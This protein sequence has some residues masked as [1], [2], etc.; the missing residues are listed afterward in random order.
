VTPGP[1]LVYYPEAAEAESYRRALR[2]PRGVVV[3]TAGTPEQ[4]DSAI[5]DTEILYGW[6]VP[7][8]LLARAPRL[9]WVQAMGAGVDR[10]L[11]PELPRRVR[12]TR[13]PV[14]GPWMVEYVLGWL[15]WVAQRTEVY[16][17]AQRDHRWLATFPDR[18]H[19]RTVL[20]IGLGDVGRALAAAAAVWGMRV[21]GVS[22]RA[23]RVPHVARVY[24]R[25]GLRRALAEADYVVVAVPLTP[26]TRGLIGEGELAAMRPHA[27][28]VNVARGPVVGEGALLA[29]LRAGRIAGAILDVFDREPLPPDHP[30]WDLPNV[31]VTP[32]VAGPSTPEEI[33]PIFIENLRRYAAGRAL[34][35]VVD[36][37]RGY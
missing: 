24:R 4:A 21:V 17:Q 15:A 29:S 1:I 28:L 23:R 37:R 19:G 8:G 7:P 9:R 36:R 3:R 16:R 18:L 12:L 5:G 35:H 30:F 11:V 20:L 6:G 33:A 31:V 25:S 34:L 13:A 27:W 2:L 26:E 14:F 22:R 32:H 10:F